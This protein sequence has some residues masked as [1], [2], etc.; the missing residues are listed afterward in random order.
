[1]E[2]GKAEEVARKIA[3]PIFL[4]AGNSECSHFFSYSSRSVL[5]SVDDIGLGSIV[6][7]VAETSVKFVV[8]CVTEIELL[9]P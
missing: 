9:S 6:A 7:K 3:C 2:A 8:V 4:S 5:V 1:M